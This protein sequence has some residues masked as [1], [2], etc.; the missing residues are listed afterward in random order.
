MRA[1]KARLP[2][3]S[4][5]HREARF[6]TAQHNTCAFTKHDYRAQPARLQSATTAHSPITPGGAVFNHASKEAR[7]QS[8]PTAHN[9]RTYKARLPRTALSH[10]EARFTTAQCNARLQRVLRKPHTKNYHFGIAPSN[11]FCCG[12]PF[13]R[14]FVTRGPSKGSR[15]FIHAF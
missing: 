11:N 8:A 15:D 4:R 5:A 13:S 2:R 1:Y 9:L 14:S 3:T 7:L 10:R 6:T 12:V